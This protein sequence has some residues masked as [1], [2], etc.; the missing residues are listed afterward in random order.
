MTWELR[1][2]VIFPCRLGI[3]F[4]SLIALIVTSVYYPLRTSKVHYPFDLE[5]ILK[6]SATVGVF[7]GA[8]GTVYSEAPVLYRVVHLAFPVVTDFVLYS[9]HLNRQGDF[10]FGA[11]RVFFIGP[12]ILSSFVLHIK[13]LV[14]GFGD[15]CKPD[16][17][18]CD[19]DS[20]NLAF[21]L[22]VAALMTAEGFVSYF[23]PD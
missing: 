4:L 15:S 17:A 11:A 2:S 23:G 22:A 12:F 14:Q 7:F 13:Y 19:A 3:F 18:A 20:I 1:S 21:A 16:L 5:A 10:G 6:V 8:M 9:M